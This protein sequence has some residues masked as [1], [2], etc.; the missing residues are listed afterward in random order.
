VLLAAVTGG[1]GSGKTTV[2][3]ELARRGAP[4]VDADRVAREVV[5]P[6]GPAYAPLRERFGPGVFRPDGGLD[7]AALAAVAFSDPAALA[8]L[9]AITHP[10]IAATVLE[11]LGALADHDGPVVLD[12]PLLGRAAIELYRPAAL[13]VVDVAEEV[14]VARLVAHRGFDEADALARIRAQASRQERRDLL[15]LVPAGRV[16]DNSGDVVALAAAV[17]EAWRWLCSLPA[18]PVPPRDPGTPAG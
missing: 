8:D 2:S 4:V 6:G 13:L 18:P 9:N 15:A 10:V 1:I 17:E 12:I 11:R 14:A 7:R 5:E 3:A 16:I